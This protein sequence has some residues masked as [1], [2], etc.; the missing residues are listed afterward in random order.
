[1]EKRQKLEAIDKMIRELEDVK[2]SQASILKKIAQIEAENINVG[3]DIVDKEIG[4]VHEQT[5][6]SLEHLNQLTE[7]VQTY[8]E[9]FVKK[10]R[11]D[12]AE[13]V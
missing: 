5:D 1:M 2:N 8:R 4:D 13:E 7:K 9:E 3:V 10:N 6:T 12:V 11:L